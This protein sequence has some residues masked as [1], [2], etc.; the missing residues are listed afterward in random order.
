M[1]LSILSTHRRNAPKGLK[2]GHDAEP[3]RNTVQRS[4][5]TFE[6]LNGSD[7]THMAPGDRIIIETPGGGGYGS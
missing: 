1:D 7:S 6:N 3:G 4:D 2:G 5:G